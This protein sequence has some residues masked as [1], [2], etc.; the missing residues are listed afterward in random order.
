MANK[1]K[2]KREQL[3]NERNDKAKKE[4]ALISHKRK[5]F[6]D[7]IPQQGKSKLLGN[8]SVIQSS[9]RFHTSL[10]KDVTAS[11]HA[12]GTTLGNGEA[13]HD[14][15]DLPN[16]KQVKMKPVIPASTLDQFLKDQEIHKDDETK[17][18]NN[19]ASGVE[20]MHTSIINEH[21]KGLDDLVDKEGLGGDEC[22]AEEE[23]NID[24][25]PK[26]MS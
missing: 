12:T 24:C 14:I 26:G 9:S 22:D 15:L 21:N 18:D 8:K 5:N 6:E 20:F 4:Q 7:F 1:F 2:I 23:I 10:K 13:R 16:Y 11:A 3:A 19:T 25:N 17:R